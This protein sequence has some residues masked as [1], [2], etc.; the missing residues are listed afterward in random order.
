MVLCLASGLSI[1]VVIVVVAVLRLS[2]ARTRIGVRA[3]PARA[4]SWRGTYRHFP[5]TI[6]A[7]IVT[8]DVPRVSRE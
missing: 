3:G 2:A 7:S 1:V 6:D 8:F 5:V 4:V